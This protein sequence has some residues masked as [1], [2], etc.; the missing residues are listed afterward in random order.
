[1]A[2]ERMLQRTEKAAEE[3]AEAK[4]AVEV[5]EKEA[6]EKAEKEK[7]VT[8]AAEAATKARQHVDSAV[9]AVP[10]M[11]APVAWKGQ[12]FGPR[13]HLALRVRACGLQ[14]PAAGHGA[15]VSLCR[16]RS[17]CTPAPV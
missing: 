5:A 12:G 1:M 2:E 16:R 15:A 11:A 17:C 6:A 3:A 8:A 14:A 10:Q 4:V 13:L 9:F 7:G